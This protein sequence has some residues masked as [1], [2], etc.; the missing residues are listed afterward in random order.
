MDLIEA[1]FDA[2]WEEKRATFAELSTIEIAL[3]AM[4]AGIDFGVAPYRQRLQQ[5]AALDVAKSSG[6]PS[7]GAK[8]GN[9]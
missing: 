6:S 5:D 3:L 4:R 7:S 8:E 2:W 9:Q 1:Y